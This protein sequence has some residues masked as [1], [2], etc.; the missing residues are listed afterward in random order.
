MSIYLVTGQPGNGKSYYAMRQFAA[1]VAAGKYI[2]T[3]IELADDWAERCSRK[4]WRRL[5]PGAIARRAAE[6]RSRVF[7]TDDLAEAMRVR[8]PGRKE[9]R[10]VAVLDES[11]NWMNARSWSADDRKAIVRWF[12]QHR[13]LGFDVYLITQDAEMIDKQVRA[14]FEVHIQLRNLGKA[15]VMGIRVFPFNLFLAVHVWAHGQK[16]ILK[17]EAF[18]LTWPK[19]L[20]DTMATSHG[21]DHSEEDA[22]WLPLV[23]AGSE[24]ALCDADRT[25]AGAAEGLW[26]VG[27]TASPPAIGLVA[28]VEPRAGEATS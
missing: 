17:R 4:G 23:P 5:W 8:V 13:K 10:A 14:L 6:L 15:K 27:P 12:S 24:S 11:H 25:H 26:S 21:L 18:R 7:F 28:D 1:S 16:V 9:G 19:H 2:V 3:N 20:Y 22:I